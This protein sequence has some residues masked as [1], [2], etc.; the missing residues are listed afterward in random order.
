MNA[1]ERMIYIN[2]AMFDT[3]DT[4]DDQ[5]RLFGKQRM[6]IVDCQCIE[7]LIGLSILCITSCRDAYTKRLQ[8][9]NFKP[10]EIL[11]HHRPLSDPDAKKACRPA[12]ANGSWLVPN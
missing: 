9:N 6:L 10:L 4:A 5:I 8:G 12:Y 2:K 7:M 1:L 11:C 3:G